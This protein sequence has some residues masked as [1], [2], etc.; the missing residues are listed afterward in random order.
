VPQRSRFEREDDV[1]GG[2]CCLLT[3]VYL[4]DCLGS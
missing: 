3:T 2:D 1:L 4:R